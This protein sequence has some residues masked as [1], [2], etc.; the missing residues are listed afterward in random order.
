MTE[1]EHL[2]L[3]W[4]GKFLR[5]HHCDVCAK[6]WITGTSTGVL[7]HQCR[8]TRPTIF[9]PPPSRDEDRQSWA[10]TLLGPLADAIEERDGPAALLRGDE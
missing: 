8:A 1:N 6:Q 2:A 3:A 4:A 5:G 7:F 9:S 10:R